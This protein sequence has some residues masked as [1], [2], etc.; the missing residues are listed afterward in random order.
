MQGGQQTQTQR[1]QKKARELR[2]FS[3]RRPAATICKRGGRS[4]RLALSLR[5][6]TPGNNSP[7]RVSGVLRNAR[8]PTPHHHLFLPLPAR[9]LEGT[10]AAV[11]RHPALVLGAQQVGRCVVT[12]QRRTESM[13]RIPSDQELSYLRKINRNMKKSNGRA[14]VSQQRTDRLHTTRECMGE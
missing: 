10:S 14:N 8:S 7:A 11:E 5:W 12:L 13:P 2:L 4:A 9:L 6:L 1:L 3:G